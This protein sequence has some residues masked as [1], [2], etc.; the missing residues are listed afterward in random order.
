MANDKFI[1]FK[2]L[3]EWLDDIDEALKGKIVAS[4]LVDK[5]GREDTYNLYQA[6]QLLRA[7]V[8]GHF[9]EDVEFHHNLYDED[10]ETN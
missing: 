7:Q 4:P 9:S 8:L 3:I 1:T 2:N 5:Q 10:K 6:A